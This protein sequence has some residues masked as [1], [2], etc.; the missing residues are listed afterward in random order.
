MVIVCVLYTHVCYQYIYPFLC[1]CVC[2]HGPGPVGDL[3]VLRV[4]VD[5]LLDERVVVVE[6]LSEQ[7]L[8]DD[9]GGSVVEQQLGVHGPTWR[10]HT[11]LFSVHTLP[12][13]VRLHCHQPPATQLN[14]ALLSNPYLLRNTET[15][16]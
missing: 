16:R 5:E 9:V 6:A 8:T 2:Y 11:P 12:R 10:T 4:Q 1:V 15:G 3:G 7:D 14:L 13:N